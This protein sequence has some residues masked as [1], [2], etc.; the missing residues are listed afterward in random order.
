VNTIVSEVVA[1]F[2]SIPSKLSSLPSDM[3]KIGKDLLEG[4]WN[5]IKNVKGWLIG[6]IKGLGSSVLAG[7]RDAFDTHSPSRETMKIGE[8][9]GEGLAIGL[10]NKAA[11]IEDAARGISNIALAGLGTLDSE[12]GE[13]VVEES[14]GGI[15]TNVVDGMKTEE[16]VIMGYVDELKNNVI[17]QISGYKPEFVNIGDMMMDGIE[18]GVKRGENGVVNAMVSAVKRAIKAAKAA[19]KIKSPSQEMRDEVGKQL[20]R[21]M[22]VG[23]TDAM[24]EPVDAMSD[25]VA[26][27]INRGVNVSRDIDSTFT[28]AN[29]GVPVGDIVSLLSSYLPQIV[30][31]SSRQIVLDGGAIVGGTVDMIDARLGQ[32]AL[33][34]ARGV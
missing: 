14:E 4:L 26:G 7:I 32:S 20:S 17:A 13:G 22:A 10:E 19:A 34:K 8:D 30:D 24:N 21:G 33:L 25:A 2:K 11:D 9:V 29:N 23:I 16:P 5:G 15:I 6:K 27:V 3:T 18:Q 1:F 31:A 28:G 12:S